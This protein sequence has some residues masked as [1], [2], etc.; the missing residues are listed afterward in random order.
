M[1]GLTKA[2]IACLEKAGKP[3]G[4]VGFGQKYRVAGPLRKRG[5]LTPNT[6][7]YGYMV[8]TD[9]GRQALSSQP[10]NGE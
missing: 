4:V 2:Q 5:F 8:L 3:G 7:N 6:E 10:Q 1:S 9:A